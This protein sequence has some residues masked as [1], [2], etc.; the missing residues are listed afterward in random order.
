M[1]K[2]ENQMPLGIWDKLP[3]EEVIKK[4]KINFEVN[5]P[6]E[7]IFLT[8]TPREYQSETGAYYVFEVK[9]NN[10][11]RAIVTSAWTLLRALKIMTPLKNKKVRIVKKLVKGKQAFEVVKI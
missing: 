1:E 9:V 11:E 8:D 3:T 2:N 6:V 7:V 5:I 10:E 4:P